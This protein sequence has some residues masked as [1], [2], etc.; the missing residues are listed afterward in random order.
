MGFHPNAGLERGRASDDPL[1]PQRP[2]DDR[3]RYG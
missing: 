1:R 2:N 3:E